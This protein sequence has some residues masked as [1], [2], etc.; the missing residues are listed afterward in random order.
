[1]LL[2]RLQGLEEEGRRRGRRLFAEELYKQ[3]WEKDLPSGRAS[4]A[5]M[6]CKTRPLI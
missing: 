5:F 3:S 6:D 2:N 1:M 4:S